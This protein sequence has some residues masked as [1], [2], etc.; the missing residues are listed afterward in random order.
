MTFP[1]FTT[2][3]YEVP[4]VSP[5][6]VQ[7]NAPRVEQVPP[8][9]PFRSFAVAEYPVMAEPPSDDGAVQLTMTALFAPVA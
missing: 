1:A 9:F 7:V 6:M 3:V 4:L 5:A 8:R 2:T